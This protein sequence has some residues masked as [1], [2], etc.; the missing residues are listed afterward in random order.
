MW[1]LYTA[2][3]LSN[4]WVLQFT[5]FRPVFIFY[6]TWRHQTTLVFLCF[7]RYRK[8]KLA[9]NRRR[10]HQR[11]S[12]KK[13]F[14]KISQYSQVLW[15]ATLLKRDSNTCIFLWILR[16]FQERLFWK[17]STNDCFWNQSKDPVNTGR[18]LN[19][20]KTFRRRPGRLMYVQFT[21]CVYGRHIFSTYSLNNNNQDISIGL[22]ILYIQSVL[23]H[24]IY[25][26]GYLLSYTKGSVNL[27][28]NRSVQKLIETW[29]LEHF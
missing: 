1:V 8:K 26:H 23:I 19:V 16:N 5:Y 12:I 9:W 13:L 2:R 18:K 29:D 4:I 25:G 10:G 17:I 24:W 7:Q 14:L 20:H 15:P 21:S 22:R 11:C 28:L 27:D 3:F 6:T